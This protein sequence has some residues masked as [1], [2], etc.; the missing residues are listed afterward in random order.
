MI[1]EMKF[2]IFIVFVLFLSGCTGEGVREVQE[3]MSVIKKETRVVVPKLNEP[4]SYEAVAYSSKGE[5]DPFNSAK[6]LLILAR[7]KAESSS[8]LKPNLERRREAL[9]DFPLDTLKMVGLIEDRRNKNALIQVDKTVYQARVGNY[10]GQNF[11][12]I[13]KITET[14]VEMK[15]VVQDAAGEWVERTAKLELQEIKK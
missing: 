1:K 9:E 11:G 12:M 2:G 3:W 6:L 7:L 4:K 5:T 14:E 13:T 8:G 10:L 15:E